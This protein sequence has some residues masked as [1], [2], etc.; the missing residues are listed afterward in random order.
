MDSHHKVTHLVAMDNNNN[1]NRSSSSLRRRRSSLRNSHCSS[2]AMTVMGSKVLIPRRGK[3]F[4]VGFVLWAGWFSEKV[5]VN[6]GL[7]VDFN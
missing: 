5:K 4:A 7:W 3:R 1:N 2:K 6:A